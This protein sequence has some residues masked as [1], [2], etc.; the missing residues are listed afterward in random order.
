MTDQGQPNQFHRGEGSRPI[1]DPTILT[2]QQLN[3][4][5]SALRDVITTRLDGMDKALEVFTA[6]LNRVP[7]DVDVKIA[8]FRMLIFERI[9]RV[10]EKFTS[11]NAR[12]GERDLRQTQAWTAS[13]AAVSAALEAAE[14]AVTKSE[15][16]TLKL[17]DQLSAQIHNV[18]KGQDSQIDDIKGRLIRIEEGRLGQKVATETSQT[19]Y[20]NIV[21]MVGLIVGAMIGV[22]SLLIAFTSTQGTSQR[23]VVLETVPETGS[24]R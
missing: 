2:T 3:R 20:M 16:A 22:G 7:S 13:A 6:N 1:P 9:E 18:G 14:K 17:I 21:G 11:V 23:P 15:V 5:I 24:I 12:F 4:E 8:A 10:E 19:S